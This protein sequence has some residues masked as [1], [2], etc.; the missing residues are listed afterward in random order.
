MKAEIENLIEL[1]DDPVQ[2]FRKMIDG[3][4]PPENSP[5]AP[6]FQDVLAMFF[7]A[8]LT[9]AEDVKDIIAYLNKAK[10]N[11]KTRGTEE[12]VDTI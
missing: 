1:V 10:A 12:K 2:Y 8:N 4:L 9:A 3:N 6:K 5:A 7:T 11:A